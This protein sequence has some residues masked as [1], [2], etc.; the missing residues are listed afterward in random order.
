M[1]LI[2]EERLE[3]VIGTKIVYEGD[4]RRARRAVVRT[5]VKMGKGPSSFR[6]EKEGV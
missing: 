2:R 5:R 6:R 1:E 4:P 3:F